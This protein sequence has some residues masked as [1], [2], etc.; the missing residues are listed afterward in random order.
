MLNIVKITDV[1][2]K[3]SID[4]LLENQNWFSSVYNMSNL[5]FTRQRLFDETYKIE[6]KSFLLLNDNKPIIAFIGSLLEFEGSTNLSGNI[7]ACVLVESSKKLTKKEKKCFLKELICSIDYVHGKL[8]YRDFLFNGKMSFISEYLLSEGGKSTT[9]FFRTIDLYQDEA[10]LKKNIRKRYQSFVNW[11]LKELQPVV[12]S[13]KNILID[14]ILI[15]RDLHI[16]VSGRETRSKNS[17]IKQYDAIK[18]GEAFI[19]FGYLG[20]ELVSAGYFLISK[21][22]CYYGV[23]ASRRDLFDKPIFHSLIWTAILHAKQI[24]CHW[25]DMGDQFFSY[26]PN[27]NHPTLKELGISK[28]KGGFGGDNR[29]FMDIELF[30]K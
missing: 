16:L 30:C 17:W 14:H 25:F 7:D 2:Y 28:F 19:V 4:T 26:D 22:N 10:Y 29:V 23:S 18:N 8:W 9:V 1:K 24:G 3:S 21:T 5:D 13:K 12:Y 6:D 15:F 27:S 20:N 11:G